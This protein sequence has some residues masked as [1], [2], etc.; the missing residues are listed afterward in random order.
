MQV[1]A[2]GQELFL[3]IFFILTISRYF[4]SFFWIQL[5]TQNHNKYELKPFF[6]RHNDT[7]LLRRYTFIYNR[8]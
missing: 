1:T 3:E 2:K 6:W 4:S 7:S 5:D 8:L